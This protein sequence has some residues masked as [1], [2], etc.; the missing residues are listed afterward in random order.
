MGMIE[1]IINMTKNLCPACLDQ[2]ER[3]GPPIYPGR[4]QIGT[5]TDESA[6]PRDTIRAG[7]DSSREAVLS[8]VREVFEGCSCFSQAPPVVGSMID[9]T[10]DTTSAGKPPC[11][12]CS[13]TICSL[14]AM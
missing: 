1:G 9:L 12:A 8:V 14:G 7:G 6:R 13:R 5:F 3:T 4:S 2:D 11:E 10:S